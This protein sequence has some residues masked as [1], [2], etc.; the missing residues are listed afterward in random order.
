MTPD[1]LREATIDQ[2]SLGLIAAPIVIE[3]G[4]NYWDD[5]LRADHD[6]LAHCKIQHGYL[7]HLSRMP[8]DRR[9][10]T[11]DLINRIDHAGVFG[12]VYV[13]HD[14][15]NGQVRYKGLDGK[16]QPPADI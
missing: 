16:W 1:Q 3:M 13:H 11:E 10:D 14:I 2:F 8:S 9:E 15:P 6:N 5:H 4:L 7:V 12:V